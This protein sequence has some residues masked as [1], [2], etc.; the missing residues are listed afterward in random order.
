MGFAGA[1]GHAGGGAG[2]REA[3]S[4][5]L[6]KRGYVLFTQPYHLDI[7]DTVKKPSAYVMSSCRA[8]V[9]WADLQHAA[10]AGEAETR[11]GHYL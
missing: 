8:S 2:E 3:V 5:R 1:D 4:K 10:E 7:V 11:G 6:R 9:L